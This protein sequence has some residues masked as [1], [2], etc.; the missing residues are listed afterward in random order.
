VL[1]FNRG[2]L[3]V[4][5][6]TLRGFVPVSHLVEFETTATE[7]DRQPLMAAYVGSRMC[8]KVIE[9]D[10]GRGRL[11]LSQRAAQ[12]G[13]GQR[14]R[15]LS[16]LRPGEVVSGV[17]T[18]ITRFGVFV[19]LGGL[20]GLIHVSEL[21]WGRVRHPQDVVAR[22]A[23]LVMVLLVERQHVVARASGA[24]PIP[25]GPSCMRWETWWKA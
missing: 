17:V 23:N 15:I 14:Q 1:G 11:V 24:A 16:S 21:S 20:E 10:S 8:L 3:L 5:A 9:L 6:R 7:Q 13:P 19:D 25:R 22:P 4:E 2:G 12:S 18:N